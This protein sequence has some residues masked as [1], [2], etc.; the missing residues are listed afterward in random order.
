M[1]WSGY[2]FGYAAPW[3]RVVAARCQPRRRVLLLINNHTMT[4]RNV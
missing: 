2:E 4:M 3:N 1:T